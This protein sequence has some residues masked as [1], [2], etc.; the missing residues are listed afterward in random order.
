MKKWYKT[1][2]STHRQS[3]GRIVASVAGTLLFTG[4][5]VGP[6]YRT[7]SLPTPPAYKEIGNWKTAQPNDNNLGG[8]WWEIFQDSELN[9]LEQQINVS[10]QNLKA[11]VAQYQQ[12]RAALR[13]VR[14]DY[15]PTVTASPSATRERFSNNRPP[16]S[17]GFDGL[18]FNDF[19]L[20]LNLSYQVNAWGRVSRNVESFREQAQ[21]SAGDLAVV[22]LS[23]HAALAVDYFAA[24]TLD[25]EEKLLQDT[26]TQ[27]QQAF[28]LNE[29]RYE[30]GL[31]S[32]VEVE[33]ARTILETTRAQMID[34]G[35]A[36]A[37]FE[38]ATAVLL[39]KAPADFTLPPLPLTAPPPPIPVG[40]PS[41]LLER[42]PDIAAAERRVA[43]A[44][45]QVGLA[46]AAY[47]PLV[48][49]LGTGGFESGTIT[50]LL[51]GPSAL[52]SVGAS[53][54]V[55]VFDVGRRRAFNDQAKAAYDS[56]V[57][58]YRETVLSS[59]QQV[60]DNLAALR[61]LEQEAGVQETA[62]QAAQRSLDLSNTRYEGGVTSYLEV[63]TAQNAA[64]SDEVTAV[65]ILGRRMASAVLLVEALGGGWNRSGLPSR[66]ECCGKLASMSS[67]P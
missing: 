8:N 36:R 28:Q 22:S 15:Y 46:K 50:T 37:Q 62:V 29:D 67:Q 31:A 4:C 11:A 19:V 58:F 2:R 40:I 53:A 45:A 51:Q 41:E 16:A 33:Q 17:S 47:Y 48:N 6:K 66:P 64:L 60:E 23:M 49:I 5:A 25:A 20:P 56:S 32:E 52:W 9:A 7:P 63:I 3:L 14:A 21:A 26:V 10:N 57:A 55:T 42:R 59:F 61:V 54:A 34:V 24:R 39:G 18:T 65:N 43:S 27:Y 38:H 35:V 12:S 13:Y 30:G 1:Q 44:N